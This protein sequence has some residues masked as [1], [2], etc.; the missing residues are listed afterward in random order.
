MFNLISIV[1]I[2]LLRLSPLF[3]CVRSRTFLSQVRARR[4]P[5]RTRG[6]DTSSLSLT[7]QIACL[8]V[9]VSCAGD[10]NAVLEATR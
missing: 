1:V 3:A 5:H 10:S 7:T 2:P 9:A 4:A 8:V 6:P